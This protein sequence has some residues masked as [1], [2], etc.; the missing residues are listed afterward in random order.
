MIILNVF[1][2]AQAEAVNQAI[3]QG[4]E[5]MKVGDKS[6]TIEELFNMGGAMM[7]PILLLSIA[8]VFVFIICLFVTRP[9]N[10]MSSKFMEASEA[11]IMRRDFVGLEYLCEK[12]D[13]SMARIM[14]RTVRFMMSNPDIS[15]D[16]L[17]ETAA[18]EGSRQA[19]IFVRK[20]SWLS[21]IGAV[22]PMFGLLGTVTGMIRTFF[23]ISN[24]NFEGVKQMQMAGGVAEA[25]ITTAAGLMV[26]IPVLLAY[27]YFRGLV[28]KNLSNLESASTHTVTLLWAAK[29]RDRAMTGG[30]YT[31]G[32]AV[33]LPPIDDED[34][35]ILREDNRY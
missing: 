30:G 17:K 1:K 33:E 2:L 16:E 21:D 13:S 28:Q 31:P 29:R 22:A 25:L 10:V 12:D 4:V 7:W 26:G 34:R 24:G 6:Y 35:R 5:V 15:I 14:L 32:R 3:S 8:A 23:E 9:G 18:A 19:G 20:V 11:L 27:A